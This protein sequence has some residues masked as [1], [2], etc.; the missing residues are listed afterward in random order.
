MSRI[1]PIGPQAR[2]FALAFACGA[3]AF[4]AVASCAGGTQ[5]GILYAGSADGAVLGGGGVTGS[6]GGDGGVDGGADGGLDGGDAGPCV[7]AG[8]VTHVT[9]NCF[10]G[11]STT[12]AYL[13]S[14]CN[15]QMTW[16]SGSCSGTLSG[17]SD[18]FDG[19]CAGSGMTTA[20]CAGPTFPGTITCAT[21]AGSSCTITFS[22]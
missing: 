17:A 14:G 4:A 9:D 2:A 16:T 7:D 6:D 21:D 18:S 19:G 8:S 5:D 1:A 11:A 13:P 20:P 15:V 22:P 12:T 3:V 10:N